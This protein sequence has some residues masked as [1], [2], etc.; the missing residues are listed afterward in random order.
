MFSSHEVS[1]PETFADEKG[2]IRKLQNNVLDLIYLEICCHALNAL[3]NGRR[4]ATQTYNVFRTRIWYIMEEGDETWGGE[5]HWISM[6]GSIAV[7]IARA[8]SMIAPETGPI[9]DATISEAEAHL[10]EHFAHPT[11]GVF[12]EFSTAL[13]EK[14]Q[15]ETLGVARQY[16]Q[17]TPLEISERQRN[18][19]SPQRQGRISPYPD[20]HLIARRLA[21]VGVLHWWVWGPLVYQR[22]P[23]AEGWNQTPGSG[24]SRD[25][26]IQMEV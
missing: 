9:S 18:P 15:Y 26:D 4:Q 5:K 13:S 1:L 3:L 12:E 23:I 16:L 7:E 8:K 2:R 25:D 11:R 19:M 21:H 20:I 6:I 22:D 17:M 14:L 10:R 24:A